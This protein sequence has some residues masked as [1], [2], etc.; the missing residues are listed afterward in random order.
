MCAATS[1]EAVNFHLC[2][3]AN[4]SSYPQ[5]TFLLFSIRMCISLV[6]LY[7]YIVYIF[8]KLVILTNSIIQGWYTLLC[9]LSFVSV[10][11]RAC[12]HAP[13]KLK[14]V[15]Y[16]SGK[17]GVERHRRLWNDSVLLTSVA[18]MESKAEQSAPH[19]RVSLI[20]LVSSTLAVFIW[21]YSTEYMLIWSSFVTI[22]K[23]KPQHKQ[24]NIWYVY[25]K[26][27]CYCS[28]R[29]RILLVCHQFNV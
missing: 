19:S 26:T 1:V 4:T 14:I 6:Y 2:R 22:K 13:A 17:R 15:W 20:Q 29:A 25:I 3:V 5:E 24:C 28:F 18:W 16:E 7:F 27:K 10:Y 23:K 9:I 12:I 8:S 21:H 11:R